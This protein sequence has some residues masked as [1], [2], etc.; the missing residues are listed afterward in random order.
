MMPTNG[1]EFTTRDPTLGHQ[2]VQKVSGVGYSLS[3]TMIVF[4]THPIDELKLSYLSYLF[5]ESVQPQIW[6]LAVCPIHEVGQINIGELVVLSLNVQRLA[7]FVEEG[8]KLAEVD[9][10]EGG[11]ARLEGHAHVLVA[12]GPQNTVELVTASGVRPI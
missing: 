2:L 12:H 6:R 3:I 4:R 5:V 11:V 7:L 8:D 10:L 9:H 1:M